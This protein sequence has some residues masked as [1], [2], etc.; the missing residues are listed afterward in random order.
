MMRLAALAL[1]AALVT[2]PLAVQPAAPVTW[3]AGGAFVVGAVGVA[4]L[5]VPLVTGG[6]S[7]AL[8]A[9]GLALGMAR[10]AADLVGAVAVG[11]LLVLL[12][13]LVHLAARVDGAALGPGVLVAEA[14][15][16]LLVIGAGIA[17]SGALALGASVVTGVVQG[18]TLPAVVVAAVLGAV[19]ALAGVIALVTAPGADVVR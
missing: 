9:W 10:P 14:R 1:L 3:L 8:V 5:S 2:V 15:Q 18:M 11:V 7:V 17:A 19:A 12:L 4:A 13:A 16:W 6:A